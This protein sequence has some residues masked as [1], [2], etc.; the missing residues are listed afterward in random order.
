M[1][2]V[3]RSRFPDQVGN[4]FVSR[5]RVLKSNA[6]YYIGRTDWST[7]FGGFEEPYSRESDYFVTKEDAARAMLR[8]WKLRECAENDWAY[9]NGLPRPPAARE[10]KT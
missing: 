1:S 10:E 7:E 3:D 9:A 4:V 2:D 6:G 8:G 5:L